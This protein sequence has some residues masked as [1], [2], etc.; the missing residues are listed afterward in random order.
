MAD[1]THVIRSLLL[2]G[3]VCFG[4]PIA[5]CTIEEDEPDVHLDAD[6]LNDDDADIDVETDD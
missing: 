6:E 1:V 3:I 4:V 5:G 2:T